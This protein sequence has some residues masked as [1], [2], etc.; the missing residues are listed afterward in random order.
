MGAISYQLS[1]YQFAGCDSGF[2]T[3]H[4]STWKDAAS[5]E[6]EEGWLKADG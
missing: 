6:R 3:I 1:G 4:H 5:T 2:A